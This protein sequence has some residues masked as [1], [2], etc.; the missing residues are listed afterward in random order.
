MTL[1]MGWDINR[2]VQRRPSIMSRYSIGGLYFTLTP[3]R[4]SLVAALLCRVLGRVIDRGSIGG[5]AELRPEH[6]FRHDA[7][8][9]P[10]CLRC[11]AGLSVRI[12][13][14]E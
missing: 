12:S 4:V 2:L 6:G 13:N 5:C 3:L 9:V 8:A 1:N 7:N 14:D 11:L 10:A